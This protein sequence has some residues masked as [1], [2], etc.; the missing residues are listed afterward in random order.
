MG[1]ILYLCW[2]KGILGKVWGHESQVLHLISYSSCDLG[3]RNG[4][5][6]NSI[7]EVVRVTDNI[8]VYSI[9]LGYDEMNILTGQSIGEV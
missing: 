6:I 9:Q 3:D 7:V 1:V 2:K 8:I 5:V 4:Y